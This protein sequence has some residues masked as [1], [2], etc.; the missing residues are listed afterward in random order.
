MLSADVI[1]AAHTDITF[2][3]APL[4]PKPSP[5]IKN[6]DNKTIPKELHQYMD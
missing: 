5:A 1:G 2:L 4:A 6:A 3:N